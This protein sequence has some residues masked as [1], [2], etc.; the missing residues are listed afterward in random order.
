MVEKIPRHVAI[1]LDGN[2]RWAKQR[3][4]P[5]MFGHRRGAQTLVKSIRFIRESGVKYL[6]LFCFSTENWQRPAEEVQGL[7]GIF[8]S[9]IRR[10]VKEAV[11]SNTRVHWL[12]RP[13]GLPATVVEQL[14]NLVRKTSENDQFHLALAINYSGRDEI[15]RSVGRLAASP[16]NFDWRNLQ[17]ED[18]VKCMDTVNLPDVDLLIRTSGECRLSNFMLL[19]SAYAELFFTSVLWPDFSQAIFHD[20]L[21]FYEGRERRFGTIGQ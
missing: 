5:R 6:S 10:L 14:I 9:H 19:Q 20:A 15:I 12:G 11:K 2:G 18:L 13:D 4:L 16:C 1:I 3:G 8:A 17:W 7:M 21:Q